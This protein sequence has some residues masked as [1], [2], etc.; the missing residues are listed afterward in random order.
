MVEEHERALDNPYAVN[1]FTVNSESLLFRNIGKQI[2]TEKLDHHLKHNPTFSR[3][4]QGPKL[5]V[6]IQKSFH[7]GGNYG[8]LASERTYHEGPTYENERNAYEKYQSPPIQIRDYSHE[9][10]VQQEPKEYP[11]EM[12]Q[13]RVT[14]DA[15]YSTSLEVPSFKAVEKTKES[16]II[17]K[18]E[19]VSPME[20]YR[21]E[22]EGGVRNS[23]ERKFAVPEI[24]RSFNQI[25]Q[26]SQSVQPTRKES[27]AVATNPMNQN[28][29]KVHRFPVDEYEHLKRKML[30][31]KRSLGEGG[32]EV[33]KRPA[34]LMEDLN[35]K[36][37]IKDDAQMYK[38]AMLRRIN[39]SLTQVIRKLWLSFLLIISMNNR[40]VKKGSKSF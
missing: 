26:V 10:H 14:R 35:A 21:R 23:I 7:K 22:K 11:R 25:P 29:G 4:Q 18:S 19:K 8:Q 24:P 32:D 36:M 28:K 39:A 37:G 31:L 40:D 6:A 15:P 38:E 30:A 20:D 3:V 16:P 12:Y 34:F 2:I 27:L 33:L 17:F 9:K 1:P 5:N 13:K